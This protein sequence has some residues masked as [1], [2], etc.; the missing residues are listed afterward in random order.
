[1]ADV[2]TAK[3]ITDWSFLL[4]QRESWKQADLS[5]VFTN[6]VFD[7]LH[8]GHLDYLLKARNLGDLLI[9]GLNTD[10][11]VKRLKGEK[12]P[13]AIEEDR[14]FALS[15]LRQVDIVTFF[16]QDTPEQLIEA[17]LPDILVKGADYQE[18]EIVGADVVRKHGGQVVRIALTTGKS[19]T[20]LI[21][22]ILKRYGA[23]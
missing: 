16:D 23:A 1:M 12:R 17:L 3:I 18:A 22:T 4:K 20:N 6:G 11:S 9:V 15:C 13:L 5:V 2:A 8:R 7:I 21:E 10:A 19:T 14:A